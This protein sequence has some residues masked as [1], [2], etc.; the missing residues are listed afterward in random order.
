MIHGD[1][2]TDGG[3]AHAFS[4][5]RDSKGISCV[6]AKKGLFLRA[7]FRDTPTLDL[8]KITYQNQQRGRKV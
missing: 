8:S 3:T 5:K 6:V 1:K 7:R 2:T 4:E